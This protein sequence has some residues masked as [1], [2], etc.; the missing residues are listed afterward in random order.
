MQ[1]TEPLHQKLQLKD[2]RSLSFAQY[3]D[4]NGFPVIGLHGTPGS[5][6]WFEHDDP[7]SA[8]LGIYLIT[9]DR[10]GYGLSDPLARRTILD[11][12]KDLNA[13]IEHLQL[14][15]FSVFGVSGGGA[16]A[17]G[18]ASSA[19]PL[20]FKT[21]LVASVYEFENRKPPKEMCAPN[22]WGF[23]LAKRVPWLLRYTYRQQKSL[24]EKKPEL[25]VS[26]VQ[27]NLG[28]LC[29]SDQEVMRNPET[30]KTMLLHMKEA[31]RVHTAEAVN[32][33]KL[34][35]LPWNMN[36][37]NIQSPVEV[38]HGVEDTLSPIS[39]LQ[40]FLQKIPNHSTHFLNHKGHFLDEDDDVWRDI[41]IS[42]TDQQSH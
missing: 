6:I 40:K 30:A 16:Y 22:R 34:F 9:V 8:E 38:W 32:E 31:F 17:L 23:Y 2:G 36:Y 20:L 35:T 11:F 24:I 13:L 10:P 21:G 7:I 25:Y 39:G 12:N 4:P 27:K 5:R 3:G 26:S 19:H 42:L 33:M 1:G 18:F 15:R 37:S 41:L 14:K 29:I 28:H